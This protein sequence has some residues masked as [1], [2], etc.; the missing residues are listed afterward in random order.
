VDAAGSAYVT[1]RAGSSFTTTADAFDTTVAGHDAFL[2]KFDPS[3]AALI[4]STYLGGPGLDR[5]LGIALDASGNAYVAGLTASA[6]F[7]TTPGTFDP[8]FNGG[9][10]A[11]VLKFTFE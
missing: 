2:S 3:G 6:G 11:F 5:G 7:P 1:G 4:Y 8:T 10:D 9:T